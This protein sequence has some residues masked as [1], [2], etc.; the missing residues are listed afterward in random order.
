MKNILRS[1]VGVFLLLTA[2][3]LAVAQT[4]LTST[5]LSAAVTDPQAR[6]IVVASATGFTARTTVLYVDR[7][8]MQIVAVSST[9]IT[10][11]RGAIGTRATTHASGA[12]VYVGAPSYFINYDKAGTCTR[13]NEVVLPQVNIANG[14]IFDCF[15]GSWQ[16]NANLGTYILSVAPGAQPSAATP[17]AGN[18][19]V[20]AAQAGGA[21]SATTGNGANGGLASYT[22][23][24]GGAG[25]SS[26]GTGGTG[27]AASLVGGAGGGTITGGP[28]GLASVGGGAGANG[29]SAGGT[30]GGLNLYS[31]A[32]GTGGTGTD[33]AVNIRQGGAAGTAVLA[34][35]TVGATTVQ[36]VGTNQTLTLNGSGSGKV[37]LADGTDV[38][39][40][41]VINPSGATTATAT[42][43]N[44]SQTVARTLTAP[45]STGGLP[46][47][48]SCG[49]TGVGNQTCSPAAATV[50]TQV[51]NGSSTLSSNAAVITFASAFT[52]T[53]SYFCVANDIT[54]RANPVQMLSTSASTATITNTTGASDVIQWIC[55]GN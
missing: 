52:S 42:T 20:V 35:S 45:D 51:V 14:R 9:T 3:N 31:G 53:T 43:L 54:T 25:G 47:V 46:V 12:T 24:A 27:G 38:T 29:T 30:G 26:S 44:V 49:S 16:A 17:T 1:L 19:A 5:T 41:L 55:V 28:G 39:K 15:G 50:K 23:G 13:G 8:L 21:Q 18:T 10:V 34:T 32:K 22:A 36:S 33:G 7:E 6:S 4:A 48:I 37:T 11:Q 40:Q 2:A